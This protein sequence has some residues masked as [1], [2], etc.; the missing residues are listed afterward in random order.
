V[1]KNL[2]S[3]GKTPDAI[4]LDH[5]INDK[6]LAVLAGGSVLDYIMNDVYPLE[7]SSYAADTHLDILID[8]ERRRCLLREIESHNSAYIKKRNKVISNLLDT[9]KIIKDD[10][11]ESLLYTSK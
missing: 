10:E 4:S 9:S 7:A 5:F 6:N 3:Q 11:I 8:L 1:F 2:Y